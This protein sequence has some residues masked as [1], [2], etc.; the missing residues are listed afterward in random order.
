MPACD[1]RKK[2]PPEEL[3][4]SLQHFLIAPPAARLAGKLKRDYARKSSPLNLGDA[5]IAAVAI[6]FDLTLLTDNVK[7]FQMESLSLRPLPQL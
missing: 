5:I 7:D 1:P 6:H 2:L 3:F 4:A